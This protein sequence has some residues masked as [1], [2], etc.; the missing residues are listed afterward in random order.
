MKRTDKRAPRFVILWGLVMGGAFAAGGQTVREPHTFF[1][2]RI[3]LSDDRIAMID[4]GKVVAIA[5]PTGRPAEIFIFGAV[6]VNALPDEYLKHARSLDRLRR[7]PSYLGI[8]E[9]SNPPT[10]KDLDGFTLEPDDIR[11]LKNCRPGKCDVQLSAEAMK[12][13]RET[14]DWSS[15]NAAAQVNDGV[16]KMALELLLRYQE[17]GNRALAA[18]QDRN[19]RV[20]LAE[21]LESLLGRSAATSMYLPE[22]N[23]YLLEYP[24]ARLTDVESMFYWEKVAFGLKPTI[25]VNHALFFRSTGPRGPAHVVAVKQLYASHYFELALDVTAAVPDG[26]RVNEK[27]FYLISL[28]GSTQQ[29]LTGWSGSLLRRVIVSKTRAAQENT[30]VGI[31]RVLEQQVHR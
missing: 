1:K 9:F 5:V 20:H 13:L 10:L 6:Y 14:T 30:L 25:R 16:R 22:L 21:Q 29:G 2:E 18:Y 24:H 8:G 23:R 27:G 12:K 7:L 17:G 15:P 26:R 4:R 19:D 11:N 28:K 31:K 3:G